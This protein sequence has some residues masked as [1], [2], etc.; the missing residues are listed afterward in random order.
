M[1]NLIRQIKRV[2]PQASFSLSEYGNKKFVGYVSNSQL[3]GSKKFASGY[4][5]ANDPMVALNRAFLDAL[6][7]E[8]EINMEKK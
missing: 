7:K 6:H 4:A 5:E 1:E 2:W 8:Y 3:F